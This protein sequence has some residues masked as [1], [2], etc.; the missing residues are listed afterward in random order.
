MS[1]NIKHRV[2]LQSKLKIMEDLVSR[3]YYIFNETN[4]GPIDFVAVNMEG[5]V[6]FVECK[7]VSR[8]RNGS[9]IHRI[10]NESQR[11]LNKKFNSKGY[12]EIKIMYNETKELVHA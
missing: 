5:D 12:P 3:G 6:K 9:K 11:E 2:G 7:T 10:L 8:R 1:N 4:Q